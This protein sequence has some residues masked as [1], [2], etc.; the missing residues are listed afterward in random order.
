MQEYTIARSNRRCHRTDREFAAGE[1][2][3]SAV[4]AQGS[5]LVRQDFSKEA[6]DKDQI[7]GLVGW[8]LSRIPEKQ[9]ER[10]KPAPVH[11]L[12]SALEILLEDPLKGE[13]AYL[14]TLLLIRR[15]VLSE[16]VGYHLNSDELPEESSLLHL[17]HLGTNR[18]FVVPV[19][20]PQ[21][22]RMES[23]QQELIQLLF[24]EA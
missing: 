14:L 3:Y 13:L 16:P 19:C 5:S 23:L 21:A 2:Y 1:S 4:V 9:S 24:S 8:W 10:A 7:Q 11:V 20:Q 17:T 6:W 15:R 18:E 22:Q 12:L